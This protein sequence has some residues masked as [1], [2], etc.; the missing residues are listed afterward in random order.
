M[1]GKKEMKQII[2]SFLI[3]CCFISCF[4]EQKTDII[5]E[6]YM[7]Q[8]ST[9][10]SVI[11]EELLLNEDGHYVW[12]RFLKNPDGQAV[13]DTDKGCYE[14]KVRYTHDSTAVPRIRFLSED[15][16]AISVTISYIVTDSTL[17]LIG[18]ELNTLYYRSGKT[19]EQK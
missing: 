2:F 16:T 17:T 7:E 18:E 1:G 12:I 15:K 9:G 14:V 3:A 19:G 8:M 10:H 13:L 6:W 4:Q 5:G 11:R